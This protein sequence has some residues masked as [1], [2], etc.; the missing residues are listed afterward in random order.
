MT[1]PTDTAQGKGWKTK[2]LNQRMDLVMGKQVRSLN[3]V[4]KTMLVLKD[5][6]EGVVLPKRKP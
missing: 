5:W 6:F 2:R 4:R 3:D 1:D